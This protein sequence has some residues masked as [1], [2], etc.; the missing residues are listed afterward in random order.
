[1]V[2][3]SLLLN[4]EVSGGTSTVA[5]SRIQT[6]PQSPFPAQLKP[7][8]W[9]T[10]EL[11]RPRVFNALGTS[12]T[13]YLPAGQAAAS[14]CSEWLSKVLSS[15]SPPANVVPAASVGRV[16]DWKDVLRVPPPAGVPL[17]VFRGGVCGPSHVERI[18]RS[19]HVRDHKPMVR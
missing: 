4:E 1:M 3:L 14:G 7:A 17:S 6:V 16:M 13:G 11:A 18:V 9:T 19:E 15:D 8:T 5:P 10:G 2:S 12:G